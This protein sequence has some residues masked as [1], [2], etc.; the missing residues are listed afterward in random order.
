MGMELLIGLTEAGVIHID[1]DGL[2]REAHPFHAPRYDG[3]HVAQDLDGH[4]QPD[5]SAPTPGAT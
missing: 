5:A 4:F 2:C 1:A 3:A